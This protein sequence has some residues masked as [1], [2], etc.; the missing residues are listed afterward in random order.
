MPT[1]Q[2]TNPHNNGQ[3]APLE[4]N[5]E[6][7]YSTASSSAMAP[8]SCTG[9]AL[10][11]SYS[12]FAKG[13]KGCPSG[14]GSIASRHV[15]RSLTSSIWTSLGRTPNSSASLDARSCPSQ[16]CF[17]SSTI[18][19]NGIGSHHSSGSLKTLYPPWWKQSLDFC[20]ES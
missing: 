5:N 8:P 4:A 7:V 14:A 6:A 10:V 1:K 3:V 13:A 15:T 2:D 16:K 17:S 18:I 20:S 19:C 9:A 11:S 12:T